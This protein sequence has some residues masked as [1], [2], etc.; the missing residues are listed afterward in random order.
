MHEFGHAITTKRFGGTVDSILVWPLGGFAFCGPTEG[1]GYSSLIN[2]LK[3]A[4]AGPAT[5]I[6]MA[7]LWWAIYIGIV[8]GEESSG[9]SLFW[10]STTIYLDTLS[11]SVA[12]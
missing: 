11:Q 10:P 4:I 8:K 6:P 1:E 5:H 12:G 9:G 7:L 2:E 3:V